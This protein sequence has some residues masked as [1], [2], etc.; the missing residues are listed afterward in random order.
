MRLELWEGRGLVNHMA[1]ILGRFYQGI[2]LKS[3]VTEN[4]PRDFSQAAKLVIEIATGQRTD[5]RAR[6][7]KAKFR[8]P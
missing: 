3:P 1:S 5:R 8:R 4:A 6:K 2:S 7:N